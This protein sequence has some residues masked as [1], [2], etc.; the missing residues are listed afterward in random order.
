MPEPFHIAMHAAL[1][2]DDSALAPWLR[3][4]EAGRAGL[5]VYRNTVAKARADALAA[6]YPSI[7]RLVGAEWFR[8]A[9]LIFARSQPPSGPVMDDYGHGFPDWLETFPP[10]A[11]LPYLA[12][13]G[14]LDRAWSE[15]HRAAD[16]PVL[17]P[18]DVSGLSPTVLFG[19][20]AVLHPAVRLFWF[21]WT[22]PSIWRA[23]RPGSDPDRPVMWDAAPEGLLLVRPQDA[24]THHALS[25]PQWRFLDACRRGAPL[26][27]AAAMLRLDHP[28][29]DLSRLFAALLGLGVFTRLET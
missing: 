1:S 16:A 17:T 27:R 5:A 20:R 18:S 6:L 10:A 15:V 8:D 4:G 11:G 12:P 13:V 22:A 26:G 9:A 21:D 29:L 19:A 2:G 25:E 14:R 7:E 24:V 23:N 28:T 3:G